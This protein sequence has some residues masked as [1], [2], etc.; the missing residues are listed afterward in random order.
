MLYENKNILDKWLEFRAEDLARLDL[1]D[2]EHL[3]HFDKHSK[4][5]LDNLSD[6]NHSYISN[7]LEMDYLYEKEKELIEYSASIEKQLKE[8]YPFPKT[9]EFIVMAMYNNMIESMLEEYVLNKME[10]LL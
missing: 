8:T 2:K 10:S 1:N 7:E 6:E 5:I 3:P 4:N 9:N